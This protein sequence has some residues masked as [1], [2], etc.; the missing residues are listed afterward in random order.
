MCFQEGLFTHTSVVLTSRSRPQVH[1]ADE[2]TSALDEFL[3]T[4]NDTL[5]DDIL[6]TTYTI[7]Y[8]G[9]HK[10]NSVFLGLPAPSYVSTTTTR[11]Y[12]NSDD[13]NT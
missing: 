4:R 8:V 13:S 5:L 3:T 1:C 2:I 12:V 11:D 6:R 7:I 9:K 10:A